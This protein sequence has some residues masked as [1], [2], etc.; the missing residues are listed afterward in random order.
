MADRPEEQRVVGV[1]PDEATAKEAAREAQQAGGRDVRVGAPEDEVSS[2]LGEM[3]EETEHA[4]GGPSV[5]IYTKEMARSVPKW[6]AIG[7]VLGAVVALGL[8]FVGGGDLQIGARLIIAACI[9]VVAGGTIGFLIGGGFFDP[10]REAA[11]NLAAEKGVVV[12][13]EGEG[14]EEVLAVHRPIREDVVE[15]E[16][17][18]ATVT[19]E[20]RQE[21]GQPTGERQEEGQLR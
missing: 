14:T 11:S 18:V 5:G 9:G 6:T 1:Y 20:E 4:W 8:N 16:G 3:R 17:P 10:R 15:P 13:A 19:T 2:L 12:G 21:E 7:A